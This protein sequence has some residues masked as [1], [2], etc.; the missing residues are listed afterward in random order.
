MSINVES[1]E[2]WL[3]SHPRTWD[4][5]KGIPYKYECHPEI[6]VTAVI[7]VDEQPPHASHRSASQITPDNGATM[8]N[9]YG[10]AWYHVLNDGAFR[11]ILP[12]AACSSS[13]SLLLL[14]QYPFLRGLCLPFPTSRV[15]KNKY[16]SETVRDGA[17]SLST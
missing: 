8:S 15:C 13:A 1:S 12:Y 17:R 5:K 3:G 2:R 11:L 16:F 6:T 7:F 9:G 10:S 14:L 4:P